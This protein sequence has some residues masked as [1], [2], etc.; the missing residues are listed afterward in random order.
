MLSRADVAVV[1]LSAL[2]IDMR[3][4][5]LRQSANRRFRSLRYAIRDAQCFALLALSVSATTNFT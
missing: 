1:P 3:S 4:L 5:L 2:L